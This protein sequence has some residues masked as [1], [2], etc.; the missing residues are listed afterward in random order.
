MTPDDV[1]ATR[2]TWAEWNWSEDLPEKTIMATSD[3][4]AYVTAMAAAIPAG[5]VLEFPTEVDARWAWPD[6]V[7]IVF[8][9]P[10][11]VRHT[12]TSH[13]EE[14]G[15]VMDEPH[16]APHAITG[17]GIT[18][19]VDIAARVVDKFGEMRPVF[20]A[21]GEL[22]TVRGHGVTY[23]GEDPYDIV[24]GR[25][26]FGNTWQ[27]TLDSGVS[28]SQR[29]LHAIVVALGHRLTT[30]VE[31]SGL[32]RYA[33]KRLARSRYPELRV[34]ELTSGASVSSSSTPN[35][36][37]WSHRWMVRGHWRDQPCGPG[38]ASRRLTWID[39]YIKGPADKPLDI[40]PT[41]WK[42]DDL[43]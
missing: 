21:D 2:R 8:E 11:E 4:L 38:R 1:I 34:L 16:V 5:P 27:A 36:V 35:H 7:T 19:A 32:D 9:H 37:E 28:G 12:I 10:I 20:G 23:V 22:H 41:I 29:F 24:T 25:I 13:Q 39:P 40:R 26:V 33:R 3:W 43:Q 6:G 17:L 30:L 15:Y 31:P 14:G 42:T 18:G